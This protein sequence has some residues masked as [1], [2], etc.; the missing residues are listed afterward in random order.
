MSQVLA[1][2]VGGRIRVSSHRPVL[3]VAAGATVGGFLLG[4]VLA[5]VAYA[6]A[7]LVALRI[8]IAV[9]ATLVSVSAVAWR[10][11]RT[12][13]PQRTC[14]VAGGRLLVSGLDAAAFRWGAQLG[15]GLRTFA[16]TPGLYGFLGITAAIFDPIL[17][18]ATCTVY[19]AVRGS[20]IAILSLVVSRRTR[21]GRDEP[22]PLLGL[23]RRLAIPVLC[24]I[25]VTIAQSI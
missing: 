13:L 1:P 7:P 2:P 11:L 21:R 22:M 3:L 10:P 18:L 19:G 15:F 9:V 12:W 14:Q 8:G 4:L 16:V 6:I 17:V 25:A 24:L 23:E 20:T 5:L